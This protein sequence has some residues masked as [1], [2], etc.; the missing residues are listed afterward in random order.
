M[1]AFTLWQRVV[2]GVQGARLIRDPATPKRVRVELK[3]PQGGVPLTSRFAQREKPRAHLVQMID[4]Y[5]KNKRREPVALP[6]RRR[7]NLMIGFG[8]FFPLGTMS[9]FTGILLLINAMH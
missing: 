2:T 6:L 3:T 7:M 5:V 4:G 8:I 1:G 9:L